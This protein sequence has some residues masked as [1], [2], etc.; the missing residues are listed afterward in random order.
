MPEKKDRP[1]EAA[2][3]VQQVSHCPECGIELRPDASFCNKCGTR[4]S[5][6][7]KDK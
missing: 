7:E 6:G 1:V 3:T 5:E 2:K 4:V